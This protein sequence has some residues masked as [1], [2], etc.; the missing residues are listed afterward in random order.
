MHN[1]D[2]NIVLKY[3]LHNM[4]HKNAQFYLEL[5]IECIVLM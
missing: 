5:P 1:I 3:M 4:F 2:S